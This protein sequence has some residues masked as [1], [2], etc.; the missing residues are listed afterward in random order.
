M[1]LLYVQPTRPGC[2]GNEGPNKRFGRSTEHNSLK[3]CPA[4]EIV[5]LHSRQE[6]ISEE[7]DAETPDWF[8]RTVS[9]I[10]ELGGLLALLWGRATPAT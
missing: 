8:Q 5:R 4:V 9:R 2:M 1:P 7:M 10:E 6:R 3:K